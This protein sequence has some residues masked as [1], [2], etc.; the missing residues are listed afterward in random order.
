[1]SFFLSHHVIILN[2]SHLRNLLKN[3]V[4]YYN[5]IRPHDSLDDNSPIPRKKHKIYDGKI[6]RIP[7]LNAIHHLYKRVA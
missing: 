1:M 4:S 3:Y 2:D 5:R 6:V 7:I